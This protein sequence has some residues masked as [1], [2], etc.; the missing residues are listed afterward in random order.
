[1]RRTTSWGTSR[2]KPGAQGMSPLVWGQMHGATVGVKNLAGCQPPVKRQP[3]GRR[4]DRGSPV[5]VFG[6]P[7]EQH[8]G[9]TDPSL[10]LGDQS[11][12]LFIN[13][14]Q[15]LA[16]HFVVEVAQVGRALGIGDDAVVGQAQ[17]ISDA[18]SCA[19]Q[20]HGD[21]PVGRVG[22]AVEIV[23]V[24]DLSHD[25]LGQSAWWAFGAVR[26]VVGEDQRGGRQ[27]VVPVVLPDRVQK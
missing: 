12:E 13:R 17:R 26:V 20:D 4:R 6:W 11:L 7:R 18:Q 8:R 2:L 24:L 19:D 16:F 22:E 10:L 27:G 21:Q 25:M 9:V 23:R 5:G 15:G 14:D 1:M 3:V